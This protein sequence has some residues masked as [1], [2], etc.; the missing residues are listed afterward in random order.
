MS[1]PE[2]ARESGPRTRRWLPAAALLAVTAVWGSTF[3]LISDVVVRIPV[4]DLLAVRFV[5]ATVVLAAVAGRLLLRADRRLLARGAVLGLLYGAA[6]FLQTYGLA[7]TTPALS[8]LLTG[9][10]VVLTP[11]IAAV[12]FGVRITRVLAIAVGLALAGL[13]VL[14]TSGHGLALGSG[15]LL[16]LGSAMVYAVHIVALGRWSRASEALVLATVQSAV[17]AAVSVVGALPDGIVLPASGAD[18]LAVGYLAVVAGALVL[19]VQTWAQAHLPATRAA[20]IMCAEP[21]WAAVFAV[22][23]T[24]QPVTVRLVL[25]GALVVAA[26]AV[27]DLRPSLRR[28]SPAVPGELPR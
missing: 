5:L 13:V 10:Y 18:W 25:G 26:M 27:A 23:L 2:S 24:D 28:V 3:V 4:P 21:V 9:M 12:V 16:T 6:Q 14:T 22:L 17:I 7:R 1:A 8:G 11:V 20:V 19:L 15:E